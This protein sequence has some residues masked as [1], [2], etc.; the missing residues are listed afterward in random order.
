LIRE[1]FK[2]NFSY[3]IVTFICDLRPKFSTIEL[4]L[5][6]TFGHMP[7]IQKVGVPVEY[8]YKIGSLKN[9]DTDQR[10]CIIGNAIFRLGFLP[11]VAEFLSIVPCDR[12]PILTCH[13]SQARYQRLYILRFFTL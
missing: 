8:L 7:K 2:N 1:F 5:P 9:S 10:I 6:G 12:L 4:R 11:A 3:S 13:F